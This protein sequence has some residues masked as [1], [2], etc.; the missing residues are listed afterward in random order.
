MID[1]KVTFFPDGSEDQ[2][3][4]LKNLHMF[5]SNSWASIALKPR[6]KDLKSVIEDLTQMEYL[7]NIEEY[8][9]SIVLDGRKVRIGFSSW[10]LDYLSNKHQETSEALA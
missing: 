4:Y 9:T 8:E 1:L 2:I 5:Q 6:A 10:K 7:N 3:L